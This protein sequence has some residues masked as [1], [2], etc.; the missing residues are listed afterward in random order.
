[1]QFYEEESKKVKVLNLLCREVH[2]RHTA[3]NLKDLLLQVTKSYDISNDQILGLSVD[4]AANITKAVNDLISVLNRD[5]LAIMEDR[6]CSLD[7]SDEKELGLLDDV[8]PSESIEVFQPKAVRISCVAHKLQLA[9]NKFMWKNKDVAKIIEKATKISAK[10]RTPL[11]RLRMSVENVGN[12]LMNQVTRWNSTFLM[13]ERLTSLKQFCRKIE[14][15]KEFEQLSMQE[16]SWIQIENV[17]YTLESV[18]KLTTQLQA[19]DLLVSDFLYFWFAAKKKLEDCKIFYAIDLLNCI[20]EK[21]SFILENPIIL[22]GW[23]LDK[24]LSFL[25]SEIQQIEAKKFIRMVMKKTNKL[26]KIA[27]VESENEMSDENV[28]MSVSEEESFEKFLQN[29]GKKCRETIVS[30]E[31][32][33]SKKSSKLEKEMEDYGKL[34]VPRKRRNQLEWWNGHINTFPI[35]SKIALVIISTPVTEV[36]VERLFSHLKFILNKHRSRLSGPFLEDILFLRMN[37]VFNN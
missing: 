30:K 7:D 9:V 22:S 4:S 12:A 11:V 13:M 26:E 5:S 19:E 21:E 15:E 34:A 17:V 24:N 16:T 27:D 35:L 32:N 8:Y 3:M 2:K 20:Q 37:N 28:D 10:L 25:M 1:M 6:D 23:F 14:T 31:L 33:H 36:S 18:S 29:Q